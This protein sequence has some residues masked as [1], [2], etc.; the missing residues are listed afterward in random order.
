MIHKAI[1]S[2]GPEGGTVLL[3]NGIH[4]SGPLKLKSGIRL[5]LD[6]GSELFFSDNFSLYPPVK[7]RWEGTECHALQSMIFAE[8]S[9]KIIIKGEGTINGRGEKWLLGAVPSKSPR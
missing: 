4:N 5:Y 9:S 7:T 8:N 2:L 1:D 3:N 6:Q